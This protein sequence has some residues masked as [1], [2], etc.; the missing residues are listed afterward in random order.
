MTKKDYLISILSVLENEW[1]CAKWLII[2]IK[3]KEIDQDV[4][5]ELYEILN[6]ELKSIKHN[7]LKSKM[8]L[9]MKKIDILRQK[10]IDCNKK[11]TQ[12]LLDLEKNLLSV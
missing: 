9:T 8:E 6:Q 10:E 5:N 2:L 11:E 7:Q 12:E 3:D 1:P 4:L